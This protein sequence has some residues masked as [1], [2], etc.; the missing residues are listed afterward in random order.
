MH[1][2]VH[3]LFPDPQS[4][5]LHGM[6]EI[7]NNGKRKTMDQPSRVLTYQRSTGVDA[8]LGNEYEMKLNSLVYIRCQKLFEQQEENRKV[9]S[10]SVLNNVDGIGAFDDIVV[11]VEFEE[12]IEN[13]T[14]TLVEELKLIYKNSLTTQDNAST[15]S[16]TDHTKQRKVVTENDNLIEKAVKLVVERKKKLSF[17]T[18]VE[19][20]VEKF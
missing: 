7:K 20:D 15:S 2:R 19:R 12:D 4:Y 13:V 16:T 9:K 14:P 5:V 11:R 6:L 8:E 3:N 17:A 10:F 1:E 18:S